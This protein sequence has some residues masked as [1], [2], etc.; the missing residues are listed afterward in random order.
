MA[1]RNDHTREELREM[2]ISAAESIVAADGLAALSARKVTKHMGYSVGTLYLVFKNLDEL[3]LAVNG[4]TLD[5]IFARLM[6]SVEGLDDGRDQIMAFATAYLRYGVEHVG[7][8]TALYD[9]RYAA[10]EVPE[11]YLRKV[12]LYFE[13]IENAL[14]KVAPHRSRLDIA[15][16]A[17]AIWGGVHG[18]CML[19][20]T[21][22]LAVVNVDSV[23]ALVS[24]LVSPFLQG[25]SSP[26]ERPADRENQNNKL[27]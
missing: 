1:R 20:L 13:P 12:T 25:W 27:S 15:Q 18:I 5:Q 22:K 9:H 23:Q 7:R 4:R 16:G 26:E 21:D 2:A 14:T 8:W 24:A 11:W 6:D 19:A 17:R 10:A 3:I